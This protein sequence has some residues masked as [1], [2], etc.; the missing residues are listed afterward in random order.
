MKNNIFIFLCFVFLICGCANNTE[1]YK[2][3][4]TRLYSNPIIIPYDKMCVIGDSTGFDCKSGSYRLVVFTDSQS[5]APCAFKHLIDWDPFLDS[6]NNLSKVIPHFI[7]DLPSE[8]RKN[9][10]NRMRYEIQYPVLFDTC[11]AFIRL[12]PQ[13]PEQHSLQVFLI[14]AHDSV[15]LVG[16]PLT[17]EKIRALY[18]DV[19]SREK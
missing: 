11:H 17:N 4:I 19:L 16:N 10:V 6:L 1:Q 7:F 8:S 13:I 3:I 15:V 9:F 2:R 14:N 18:F 12:N 5:C